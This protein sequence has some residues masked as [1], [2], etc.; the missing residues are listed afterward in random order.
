M[1]LELSVTSAYDTCQKCHP[2]SCHYN[3]E[4]VV[5]CMSNIEQELFS[6][7]VRCS[8]LQAYWNLN[9]LR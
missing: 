7:T 8:L 3:E 5:V 9:F 1:Y 2:F 6:V 4:Y